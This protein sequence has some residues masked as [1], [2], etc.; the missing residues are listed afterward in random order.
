MVS[1]G[2]P[3]LLMLTFSINHVENCQWSLSKRNE[4]PLNSI[5]ISEIFDVW[6]MDLMGPFPY[7]VG[8]LYILLAIDYVSKWVEAIVT[9]TN[10][11]VVVSGFLKSN[12]FNRFGAPHAIISDEGTQF[13]NRTI[14]A[15]LRKYGAHHRV[16]TPNHP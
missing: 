12:I 8:C 6:G 4:M 7:S 16:E 5:L 10:N 9:R 3:Y 2:I 14:E 15:V 1:F 11:V 13:Y